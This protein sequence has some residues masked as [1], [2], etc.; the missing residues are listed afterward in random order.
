[1]KTEDATSAVQMQD[2]RT[3]LEKADRT[4]PDLTIQTVPEVTGFNLKVRYFCL[5]KL[6]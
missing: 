5:H 3:A 2:T 6:F 1:V 4:G